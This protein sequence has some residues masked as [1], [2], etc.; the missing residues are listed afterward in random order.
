MNY[1][2][3]DNFLE[4][5]D[6]LAIKNCLMGNDFN[7]F[8][9]K[10]VSKENVKDGIYF[11]H[12]FFDLNANKSIFFDLIKPILNKLNLKAL[13]RIKG[14]LYPSNNIIKEHGQ[15]IDFNFKHSGFIYYVNTNDGF[16]KINKNLKIKSIENRGLFFN[17]SLK[18]NSS[19]CTTSEGRININFNFF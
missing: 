3:I 6:F 11:Y 4:K 19:S 2:I 16:T 13:I 1:K 8:Y 17:P 15:H 10:G 12:L 7:W 18:H 14:N 5:E 9:N